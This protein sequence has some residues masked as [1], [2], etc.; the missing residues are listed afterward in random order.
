MALGVAAGKELAAVVLLGE[1]HDDV[2]TGRR[3]AGVMGVYVGDNEVGRLRQ[4]RFETGGRLY[5]A[6]IFVVARFRA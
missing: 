4:G 3:G 1:V 5:V 2:G 6:M